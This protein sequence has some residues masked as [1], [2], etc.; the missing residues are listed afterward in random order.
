MRSRQRLTRTV[1]EIQADFDDALSNLDEAIDQLEGLIATWG[2]G[3]YTHGNV[4]GSLENQDGSNQ[5]N[6]K[7]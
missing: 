3:E 5:P 7:P 6:C 2:V 4:R 1:A